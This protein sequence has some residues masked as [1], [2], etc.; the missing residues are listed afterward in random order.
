LRRFRCWERR[1][2]D[3]QGT[4]LNALLLLL[5][6]PLLTAAATLRV[7]KRLLQT[8]SLLDTEEIKDVLQFSI[9]CSMAMMA[10]RCDH[11]RGVP[12]ASR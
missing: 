11:F 2:R 1:C 5:L 8:Q 3:K 10:E 7:A 12:E 4:L 9:L 6:V